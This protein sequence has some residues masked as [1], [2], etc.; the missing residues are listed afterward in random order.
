MG[1]G[2]DSPAKSP[3]A[4]SELVG[5][6]REMDLLTS[7]LDEA[8]SGKGRL[9]ML[10][11]EAG[12]GKTRLADEI[13]W[14]AGEHGALIAWGRCWEDGG[15][16]AYW[17][18]MQV[19][20]SLIDGTATDQWLET[21]GRNTPFIA[22]IV[23]EVG[24]ITDDTAPV[25]ATQDED[26][27]A[28]FDAVATVFR[29]VSK[30]RPLV[31][32]LDDLHAADE[33]SLRLLRFIARGLRA[34]R[35]LV[36]GTFIE[37]ASGGTPGAKE[38][39]SSICR[40]G[41]VLRLRGL[42][43]DAIARLCEKTMGAPPSGPALAAI[44][45]ATG[46][47]PYFVGEA[48]RLEATEGGL[49]RPD[50]SLGFK[51]P[52]GAKEVMRRKLAPLS[53][54]VLNVLSAAAVVGRGFDVPTLTAVVGINPGA[55]A[56]LLAEA[57]A[58]GVLNEIGLG[59]YG[60]T[61]VLLRETLYEDLGAA[62]RMR[63]HALAADAI[64]ERFRDDL[65]THVD[66]LAHHCFKAGHAGDDDKALTYLMRAAE[67]ASAAMAHEEAARLYH[68]ALKVAEWAGL[69]KGGRTRILSLIK[70]AERRGTEAKKTEAPGV[71]EGNRFTLE[72]DYWSIAYDGRVSRIKDSKGLRY[73]AQLL[74]NPQRELHVLDLVTAIEGTPR[75]AR[76]AREDG[77]AAGGDDAGVVLDA[78][79]KAEY[80]GRLEEL[81]DELEEARAYNDLERA[82]KAQAEMDALVEQLAAGVGLGG[83]DRRAAS[84]AERAR[85][86]VT[87][88]V[89]AGIASIGHHHPTLGQHLAI[90]VRTGTFC[91]Y[92]LDP[93]RP[94]T[95]RL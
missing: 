63:L 89:K 4:G 66:E 35:A 91:S 28:L 83:R 53:D 5:R 42:E 18:W 49:H 95:W 14:L 34:A 74:K 90:T 79:A 82:A 22:R 86:N 20:R 88:A 68:R 32:V 45:E 78:K 65:D 77:L 19:I 71:E 80:K 7:A 76:L 57:I 59:R 48:V 54:D 41:D 33:A 38:L 37:H 44:T 50:L 87:K 12:M 46:G 15:A 84:Q 21:T 16:P 23:P 11:G 56:D 31:V 26:R 67:K 8:A 75:S 69:S 27:F 39:M 25:I 9:V 2:I 94:V 51:V 64:E 81:N 92:Q 43:D 55:L 24:K 93:S 70:D 1:G 52:K 6:S 17:P 47:N 73:L 3:S 30:D 62:D 58:A 60:F 36:V 29:S 10:A 61:H 13:T 72:G 85:V 40:E